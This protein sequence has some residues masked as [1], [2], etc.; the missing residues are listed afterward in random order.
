MNMSSSELDVQRIAEGIHCGMY[1]G[2]FAT[3]TDADVFIHIAVR[4]PFLTPAL[5]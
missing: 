5:C 4:P 2:V 3:A 1:L